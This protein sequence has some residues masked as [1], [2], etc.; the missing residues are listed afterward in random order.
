[1]VS[2]AKETAPDSMRATFTTD[3]T[4]NGLHGSSTAEEAAEELNFF[5]PAV[6]D[7]WNVALSNI[8]VNSLASAD[9][10]LG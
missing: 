2:E 8:S 6:R 1:M 5:F 7:F 10:S 4:I 9:I 3:D